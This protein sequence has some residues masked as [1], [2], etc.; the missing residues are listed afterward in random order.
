MGGYYRLE[1]GVQ[2]CFPLSKDSGRL[3][4][5]KRILVL[6]EEEN[7]CLSAMASLSSG[8][9][10]RGCVGKM[11]YRLSVGELVLSGNILQCL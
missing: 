5:E 7:D 3:G 10:S 1:G 6:A 8:L 4:K 9:A 2:H 11:H